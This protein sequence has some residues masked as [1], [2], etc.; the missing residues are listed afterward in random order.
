MLA[1]PTSAL[2]VKTPSHGQQTAPTANNDVMLP[3]S[4]TCE[5]IRLDPARRVLTV[6]DLPCTPE[7]IDSPTTR[8][9]APDTP[10][11]ALGDVLAAF[12]VANTE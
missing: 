5:L 6:M 9:F 7:F 11:H 4:M 12:A 8:Y 1:L 3:A 10:G 2:T